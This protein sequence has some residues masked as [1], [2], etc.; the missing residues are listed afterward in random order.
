VTPP[1]RAAAPVV[2]PV[3]PRTLHPATPAPGSLVD[4]IRADPEALVYLLLNVG[5]GDT[6]VLLLPPDS[7]DHVRRL[8]IVDV[9]T[10]GK[11]PDLLDAL[12]A[13]DVGM[14]KPGA[15]GQVRLLVGTH[16][17]FD[18][19]GGMGD[20]LSR[21]NGPSG[22]ID[23]FWEPGYY[24][25]SPTFHNLMAR[26]EASPWI[27]R[28]QPTSGTTCYLDAVKVTVLGPGVG[29]R[30]RFDTYGVGVNDSSIT[31][32]VDYPAARIYAES[33]ADGRARL[34]R[35]AVRSRSRRILLG[36]DA[37]FSSWAQTTVDFPDLAQQH[38]AALAEEL[39]A[40]RGRD[41]LA[42]DVFKLSHH[43]S[44]HGITLELME[45]VGAKYVLVSSTAGGGRYNFPHAL[46]M[47][48]VREARQAT[49]GSG[50]ARLSDHE[51][52]IHLTG[53]VLRNRSH[54]CQ[55]SL[56]VLVPRAAGRPIRL[57]RL[58]DEAQQ[59]IDLGA[60]REVLTAPR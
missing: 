7:N 25:P 54:T 59:P 52:G 19:I 14:E 15:P 23:Q 9:A 48:A 36:A 57:F 26:L 50:A 31:L 60:A 38:N 17:H 28:L 22:W 35:R 40:A 37:Q 4:A 12:H 43:A 53:A 51:L 45:R 44:K 1:P 18:H 11:L 33:D 49:T 39:R 13:A 55:G 5:D 30:T 20:L 16:P 47:E 3:A 27:R 34:N 2:S 42:A 21:Y 41:Y 24:F 29:L 58:M 8:M 46:A 56:A 32:M 10:A 6:Q